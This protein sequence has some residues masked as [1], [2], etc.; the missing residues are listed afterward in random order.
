MVVLIYR[1]FQ[2]RRMTKRQMLSSHL[3][4]C[5]TKKLP[6][7]Q[8][9]RWLKAIIYRKPYDKKPKLFLYVKTP[10]YTWIDLTYLRLFICNFCRKTFMQKEHLDCHVKWVHNVITLS[11]KSNILH[12]CH[13]ED[14]FL[15]SLYWVLVIFWCEI[16]Q[17][18]IRKFDHTL[19]Y[20][21][22][23]YN[24]YSPIP[25]KRVGLNKQKEWTFSK[26]LINMY[27]WINM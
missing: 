10:D 5:Q 25:N 2:T 18:V 19:C 16:T 8:S 15:S 14:L 12:K 6:D 27:T 20:F 21:T 17:G 22:P 24:Q 4:S 3:K 9:A 11:T 26:N 1:Q 7:Y 23:K 13:I